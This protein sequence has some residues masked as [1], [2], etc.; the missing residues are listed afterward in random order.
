MTTI[1]EEAPADLDAIRQ[2]HELAFPAPEEADLVDRLREN[3][4][5]TLSLVAVQNERIVGH[6]AFSPVTIPSG[7]AVLTGTGLA[8]MA[9]LPDCQRQ[10]IGSELIHEGISR[11]RQSGIPFVVV[12]GHLEYYPR[13]GFRRA[14]DWNVGNEY[15]VDEE[16]MILELVPDTLSHC[17][18]IAKYGPEFA[19]FD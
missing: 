6:I 12:L 17:S 14:L 11:S 5:L 4:N 13:F 19:V 1:R 3:G 7:D 18:G 16:F 10:G 8:P 15:G 2:V 9:V